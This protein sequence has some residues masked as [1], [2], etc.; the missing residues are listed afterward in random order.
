MRRR[1]T[2]TELDARR[3]VV[4]AKLL[5]IMADDLRFIAE[6]E[7]DAYALGLA[8][9]LERKAT[10]MLEAAVTDEGAD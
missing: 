9:R 4:A 2:L 3:K 8:Q 5:V 10:H 6:Q 7:G 1:A